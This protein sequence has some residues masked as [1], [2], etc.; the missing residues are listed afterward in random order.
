LGG[1][2]SSRAFCFPSLAG[3]ENDRRRAMQEQGA[4]DCFQLRNACTAI[5]STG[6]GRRFSSSMVYCLARHPNFRGKCVRVHDKKVF[7]FL[8]PVFNFLIDQVSGSLALGWV[9]E[10]FRI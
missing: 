8:P 3:P 4:I 5:K 1:E 6:T 7:F 2:R 10:G 9:K